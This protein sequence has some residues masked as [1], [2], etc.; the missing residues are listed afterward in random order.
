MLRIQSSRNAS[1]DLLRGAAILYIVAFWHL[2]DYTDHLDF[3]NSVTQLLT[4]CVLGLFVFL[5]GMLLSSRYRPV[6]RRDVVT[7]YVRRLCR[8]YPVYVVAAVGFVVVHITAPTQMLKGVFLLNLLTGSPPRT[9]WFVEMICLFYLITPLFLH[10]YTARKAFFLGIL[11][12]VAVGVLHHI[13]GK[14]VDLRI[15]QYVF[16]Y[17]VGIMAGRSIRT[18]S[19]LIGTGPVLC[20]LV[21][22][23]LLWW[24][25]ERSAGVVAFLAT[26]LAIIMFLPLVFT[27]AGK[28]APVVGSRIAHLLSYAGFCMYLI[29]RLTMH[30]AAHL[31][32]PGSRLSAVLYFVCLWVPLTFL[33]SLVL[34]WA[35]ARTPHARSRN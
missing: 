28:A 26:Q 7:F 32:T 21:T 31:Y 6:T 12:S 8:I 1:W 18:E 19:L 5:S 29:H 11:F 25:L 4:T 34:Q 20:S 2:D 17:A 9:L 3:E 23:P 27:V 10:S 35:T 15:A 33:L 13:S 30:V 24:G 22:L 16:V 14:A